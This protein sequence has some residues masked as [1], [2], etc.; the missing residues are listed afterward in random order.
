M[1]VFEGSGKS[2]CF[3]F[4]PGLLLVYLLQGLQFFQPHLVPS[5]SNFGLTEQALTLI[6]NRDFA[7]QFFPDEGEA[8]KP[9]LK[10]TP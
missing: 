9:E 10:F 3:H 5:G 1:L 6:P 4:A 2:V 8:G 7:T